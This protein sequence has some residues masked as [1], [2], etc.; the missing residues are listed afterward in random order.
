MVAN[1]ALIREAGSLLPM[2]TSVASIVSPR[3]VSPMM[4]VFSI[5]STT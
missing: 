3:T 5:Y 2:E 1:S 4:K